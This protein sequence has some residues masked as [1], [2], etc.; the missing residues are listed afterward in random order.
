MTNLS[1]KLDLATNIT[2]FCVAILVG[3]I[4]VKQYLLKPGSTIPPQVIG[5]KLALKDVDWSQKPKNLVLALSNTCHFCS[6]S[7]PFYQRLIRQ[8]QKRDDIHVMA[9]LPQSTDQGI[10]Y[11]K[12]LDVPITDVR[13]VQFATVPISG[14]P[15]ILLVQSSGEVEKAWVGKL[16]PEMESK[17][18][19]EV[20][21]SQSC[22]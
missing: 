15:T 13:Q 19:K 1:R 11:L 14:T 10:A 9:V 8:V 3:A 17:V 16:V 5:Q 18:L 4:A 7:A 12:R 20:G 2:I 6:E 21:C 22:D